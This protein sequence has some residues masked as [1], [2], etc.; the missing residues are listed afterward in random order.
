MNMNMNMTLAEYI[1]EAEV[2]RYSKEYFDLVKEANEVELLGIYL[3]ANEFL[4]ENTYLDS[5][6]LMHVSKMFIEANGDVNGNPLP[7]EKS[8]SIK[9]SFTKR[10]WA[11][12]IKILEFLL[13]PFKAMKVSVNKLIDKF[14]KK[15]KSDEVIE[16]VKLLH[17]AINKNS[18]PHKIEKFNA[19]YDEFLE[20]HPEIEKTINSG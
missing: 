11:G 9:K 8:S 12:I 2:F 3:S 15:S 16:K 10:V 19:M 17:D 5:A 20:K 4:L 14:N 13:T 7:E 1:K 6:M 18:D